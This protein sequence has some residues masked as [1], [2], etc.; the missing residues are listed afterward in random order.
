LTDPP[1]L[2]RSFYARSAEAVA[3]ELIGVV[4]RSDIGG[5]TTT[6]RI[7]ETEAYLGP[8]DPASHAWERIGRTRRNETMFGP[9]GTAYVYRSYGIHWCLNVVTDRE[10]FPGAVLIRSL[11]PLEGRDVMLDR[12][13]SEP[14]RLTT[15]PG[16]LTRALGVTGDQD[17]HPLDRSPLLLQPSD[18]DEPPDLVVGPRIGVSRAE[19]WPLRFGERGSAWL[20]RPF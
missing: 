12:R 17:G 5:E 4:V 16:R 19:D 11:E 2:P 8:D 9:P 20:S 13:G 14:R 6:G 18:D 3:R 1:A 10:D 7:V 15:G